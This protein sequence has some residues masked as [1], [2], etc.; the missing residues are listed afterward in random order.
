M[1]RLSHVGGPGARL[2]NRFGDIGS[3]TVEQAQLAPQLRVTHNNKHPM[4]GVA[5]RWGADCGVEDFRDDLFG[6]WIRF[7]SAQR[8]RRIHSLE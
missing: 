2:I 5:G 8:P 7:E 1:M 6:Y 4:L 3:L